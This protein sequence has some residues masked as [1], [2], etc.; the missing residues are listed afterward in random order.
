MSPAV[1]LRGELFGLCDED[2]SSADAR[3]TFLIST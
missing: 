1:E 3:R 2:V